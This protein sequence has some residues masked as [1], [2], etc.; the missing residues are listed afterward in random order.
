MSGEK[1]GAVDVDDNDLEDAYE[2]HEEDED[3]EMANLESQYDAGSLSEISEERLAYLREKERLRQ[4]EEEAAR[5]AAAARLLELRKAEYFRAKSSLEA[6]RVN[7]DTLMQRFAGL[8][9][10]DI[11]PSPAEPDMADAGSMQAATEKIESILRENNGRVRAALLEYHYK[12]SGEE[13][14]E[15]LK[16]WSA[17][18][19]AGTCRT[20]RDII[21]A[22]VSA[23]TVQ[24]Q[25]RSAEQIRAMAV[26]AK[27]RMEA[28]LEDGGEPVSARTLEV[29][30][31][32]LSASSE[33]KA[34]ESLLLLD[35][36]IA[37]E[38]RKREAEKAAKKKEQENARLA[39]RRKAVAAEMERALHGMGYVV[40]G[41]EE[42][43]FAK[44]G[45]L[46][47]SKAEWPN[48]V[49]R[50]SLD[51]TGKRIVSAPLRVADE[52][53]SG[54]SNTDIIN[55][56]QADKEFD[57]H[58]CNENG[59]V[60]FREEMEKRGVNMRFTGVHGPGEVALGRMEASEL[61]ERLLKMRKGSRAKAEL[62]TRRI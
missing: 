52:D 2:S 35:Q 30:D 31:A 8:A 39:W 50:I 22:L 49:L 41:V 4:E 25:L 6:A 48:H 21:T 1:C 15:A 62:K 29:L 47:A 54:L 37:I 16:A 36:Q 23:K 46:Y 20:A 5:R 24:S 26:A 42:T 19:T 45:T 27:R 10:D 3:V 28:L 13:A 38:K 44:D 40:S 32:V 7:R 59:I 9:L 55:M 33:S 12:K 53:E 14:N 11:P 57:S 18:F 17:Q 58:W 56:S 51:K 61:G 43:A 60:R 34:Q